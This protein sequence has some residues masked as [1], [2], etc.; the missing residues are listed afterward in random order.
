MPTK[1]RSSKSSAADAAADTRV[2]VYINPAIGRVTHTV[3]G[4]Q[5]KRGEV[6]EYDLSD[7]AA[8]AFVDEHIRTAHK[9]HGRADTPKVFVVETTAQAVARQRGE[10]EARRAP[11][12]SALAP[13]KGQVP[14]KRPAAPQADRYAD[15]G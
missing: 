4:I 1:Q 9:V 10:E 3:R 8:R 15:L 12:G 2:Q 14:R 7:P 13:I 6:R 11:R 5:F